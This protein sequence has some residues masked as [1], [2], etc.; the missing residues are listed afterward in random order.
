VR[1]LAWLLER[2]TS[3]QWTAPAVW[4]VLY[5]SLAGTVLSFGL[6]F[7]LLRHTPAHELSLVYLP[8]ARRRAAVLRTA[9]GHEPIT[10]FTLAGCATI[11]FGVFLGESSR[12]RKRK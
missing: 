12:R 8:D 4:S 6:Y 7:W 5:L 1:A 9:S 3:A 11:L 2:D 10:G